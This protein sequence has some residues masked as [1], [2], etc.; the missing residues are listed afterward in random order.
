MRPACTDYCKRYLDGKCTPETMHPLRKAFGDFVNQYPIETMVTLRFTHMPQDMDAVDKAVLE[1]ARNIAKGRKIRVAAIGVFN[2]RRHPHIHLCLF[3]VR[4]TVS[5]LSDKE[6]QRAWKFGSA[7]VSPITDAGGGCYIG[8]NITPHS[9]EKSEFVHVS[10]K[11]LK[12]IA[13]QNKRSSTVAP[14]LISA[15]KQISKRFSSKQKS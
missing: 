14:H 4:G 12:R 15:K 9:Q 2:C 7:K 8:K 3:G 5:D 11:S 13:T 1:F 6:C 10:E